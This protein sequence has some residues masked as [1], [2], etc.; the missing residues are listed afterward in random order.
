MRNGTFIILLAATLPGCWTSGRDFA[1][2]EARDRDAAE[3]FCAVAVECRNELEAPRLTDA[4][5]R[6]WADVT[7]VDL[8]GALE[9]CDSVSPLPATVCL[10]G[11]C[12]IGRVGGWEP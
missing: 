11:E 7:G 12:V 9:H 3:T 6:V 5:C 2:A 4:G 1:T 10:Y 8:A